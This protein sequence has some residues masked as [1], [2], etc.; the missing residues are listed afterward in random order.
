MSTQIILASTSP[1]RKEIMR[2]M[3]LDFLTVPADIDETL[4]DDMPADTGVLQLAIEKAR[5]TLDIVK[6]NGTL[7]SSVK[8]LVIIGA[9]TT[10]VLDGRM[11]G[12]PDDRAHAIEILQK[13]NGQPHD[14]FT[15]VC[16][17]A[18]DLENNKIDEFSDLSKSRV[19]FRQL[20]QTE[21]ESYVDSK[22]PMDKAGAYAL[23]GIGSALVERIDG[24]FTNVIGLSAPLAVSLLRKAGLSILGE[25]NEKQNDKARV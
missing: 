14:V 3:G 6:N 17:I 12:K 23:Q 18:C 8:K 21:I 25:S 15:G 5:T 19:Y 9:D 10:V 4:P 13:L 11:V 20:T 1:R 24:C 22:E 7:D 2:N 16:V